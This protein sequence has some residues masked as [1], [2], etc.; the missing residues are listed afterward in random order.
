MSIAALIGHKR[1]NSG[2]QNSRKLNAWNELSVERKEVGSWA[3]EHPLPCE[4]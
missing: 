3:E 1:V 2:H 4:G